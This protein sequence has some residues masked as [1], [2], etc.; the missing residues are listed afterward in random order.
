[1]TIK[2]QLCHLKDEQTQ[3]QMT[4]SELNSKAKN[5]IQSSFHTN[6]IKTL[7]FQMSFCSSM[8]LKVPH[9]SCTLEI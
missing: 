3:A 1:M 9:L 2:I 5:Q 6:C 7:M 4:A 8:P